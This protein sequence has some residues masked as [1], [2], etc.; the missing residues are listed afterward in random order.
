MDA[1]HKI[2][3][4]KVKKI[5]A[6]LI[7]E[8]GPQGWWPLLEYAGTNP[9]KTGSITGYHPERYDLPRTR[10]Q[11]YQV[12]VGAI[13]TQSVSWT[14]VEK[15]LLNLKGSGILDPEKLL[16][17]DNDTLCQ[18]I[19]PAGYFNQKA[20]KLKEFTRFFLGSD[21]TP[22]REQLLSIWGIGDETA[23]S[24]LLYAFKTPEFVVDTY[25]R[26]IFSN[27]GMIDDKADYRAVKRFFE[28]S[29]KKDLIIY[30]EYHALIVEH[31]K[32]YYKGRKKTYDCPLKKIMCEKY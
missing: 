18:M 15:A 27:L 10:A 7:A 22:T 8:Y 3:S 17:A 14:S 5:Y 20:R 1:P 12:C 32:R 21:K 2:S 19:K 28:R 29:L 4:E 30:L 23:D 6:W 13:L 31:A 11:A 25:T 16:A 26:R 24:I 9:T